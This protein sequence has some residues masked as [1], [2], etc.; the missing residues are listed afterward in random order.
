MVFDI[1]ENSQIQTEIKVLE[2]EYRIT[3]T[4]QQAT[5]TDVTKLKFNFQQAIM[6]LDSISN[7]VSDKG[8]LD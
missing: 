7:K 1:S 5:L 8:N 2:E 6:K 3:T 4:Q